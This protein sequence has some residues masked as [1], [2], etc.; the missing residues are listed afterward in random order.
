M[1]ERTAMVW[2]EDGAAKIA[3]GQADSVTTAGMRV[4]LAEQPGFGQGDEVAVRLCFDRES[5]TVA[6]TARVGWVRAVIGAF[7]CG[8][9]WSAP[10]SE[11]QALDALLSHA[12]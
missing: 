9:Q 3:R 8:L 5:P 2:I 4:R 7:E 1:P 6:T 12:A 10:A 11:R